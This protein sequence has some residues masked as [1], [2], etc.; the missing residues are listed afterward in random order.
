MLDLQHNLV[1]ILYAMKGLIEA[2]MSHVEESRFKSS[3][4][5]LTHAHEMMRKV[6][7]QIERAILVTKRV[8]LAM[9][10]SKKWEEPKD[11]VSIQE[12]WNEV[13]G[14]LINQRSG[15][16]LEVIGHIPHEFPEILCD[17][18]D[19]CEIFYCLADNAIQAISAT[20]HGGSAMNSDGNGKGKLI[21]RVNLGFRPSEERVATIT[22]ADTG[23]GIP[24]EAL[25]HLFEPFMT[26]KPLGKGNGLGLCIVRGL[27]QK[28]NGSIS[29]SS[30]RDCGTTFT[31]TFGVAKAKDE[32]EEKNLAFIR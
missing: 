5:A 26:T 24:E 1:S 3:E 22:V 29:V 17:R 14:I 30:F 16:G 27:V 15:H 28:N 6:Y 13:I 19:L 7:A 23:P 4:E 25:A 12:V 20:Q 10:Q 31:L 18:N 9:S 21:I 2:H 11:Q 32:K 8:S